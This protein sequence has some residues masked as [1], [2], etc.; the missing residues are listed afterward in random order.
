MDKRSRP[1]KLRGEFSVNTAR[2]D[3]PRNER[4]VVHSGVAV[5][6]KRDD[7]DAMEKPELIEEATPDRTIPQVN[8]LQLLLMLHLLRE[9]NIL[10]LHIYTEVA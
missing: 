7:R 10:L 9:G 8:D 5:S 2:N 6:E 4:S 3:G 1:E